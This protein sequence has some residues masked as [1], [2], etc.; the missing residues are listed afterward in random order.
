M[1]KERPDSTH[2]FELRY[3]DIKIHKRKILGKMVVVVNSVAL[4]KLSNR[5]PRTKLGKWKDAI[6]RKFIGKGNRGK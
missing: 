5:R 2:G 1:E 4:R 6:C 3:E